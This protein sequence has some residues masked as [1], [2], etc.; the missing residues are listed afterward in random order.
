[1][2]V[3]CTGPT[4]PTNPSILFEAGGGSSG[5]DFIGIQTLLQEDYTVCSYDRAG[6][7][8][9]YQ[10]APPQSAEATREIMVET[11]RAVDFPIDQDS[12]V[13]CI[14]HSAGGQLCRDYAKNLPSIKA[15]ILLDSYP[16]QNW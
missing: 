6:Y 10:A 4:E 5:I 12:T 7:G 13:V 8:K 9:S 15:I 1:M 14:G 16:V 3:Y 2:R 11:M